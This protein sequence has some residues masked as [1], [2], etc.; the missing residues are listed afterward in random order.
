MPHSD[1]FKPRGIPLSVLEEVVLAVDEFEAI[2]LAD[3]E[4]LYQ[5]QAAKKMNVSRQTFGRIIESAHKKVAEALVQGKALRIEG[6]EF[7]MASM[8]R[9]TCS[10]CQHS[11]ELPYGTGRPENCPSCKSGNIHRAQE[12]SGYARGFGKGQGR[13]CRV[14]QQKQ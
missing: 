7:E 6:G 9:F 5:E 3:L 1:Y 13:C 4:G 2:R 11:W 14:T 8:R 12:D 10:E